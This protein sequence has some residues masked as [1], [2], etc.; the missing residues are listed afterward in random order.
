MTVFGMHYRNKL[1]LLLQWTT[2]IFYKVMQ[3]FIVEIKAA[4][5]MALQYNL[6]SLMP[7]LRIQL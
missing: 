1:L 7:P 2:L 5:T 6:Y 3:Q 4:A